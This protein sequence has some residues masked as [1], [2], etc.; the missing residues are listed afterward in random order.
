MDSIPEIIQWHGKPDVSER[1][2]FPKQEFVSPWQAA[3]WKAFGT[4]EGIDCL[5]LRSFDGALQQLADESTKR[6]RERIDKVRKFDEEEKIVLALLA[7]GRVCA[8]GCPARARPDGSKMH[9]SSGRHEPI[10]PYIFRNSNLKFG[11]SG[12]LEHRLG[13]LAAICEG[14]QLRGGPGDRSIPLYFDVLFPI[15]GL[16]AAL[17]EDEQRDDAPESKQARSIVRHGAAIQTE[18]PARG[19]YDSKKR[20]LGEGELRRWYTERRN[21]LPAHAEPPTEKVDVAAVHQHFPNHKVTRERIRRQRKVIGWNRTPGR[22]AKAIN[23]PCEI[24]TKQLGE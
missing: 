11:P 17:E 1:Y 24:A 19:S 20:P 6:Y 22:P 15:A 16:Q 7:S 14:A 3:T 2:P 5:I 10:P 8:T 13:T 18:I 9:E 4:L 21:G 23:S 12:E